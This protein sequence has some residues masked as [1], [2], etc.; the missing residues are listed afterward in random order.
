MEQEKNQWHPGFT[1]AMQME[2]K[3]NREDLVF[4][5]EHSLSKK[6]L[7]IDLLVIKNEKNVVLKNRIGKLFKRYNVLEYKSPD[8]EMGVDT[9]YKVVAYACLY[10]AESD[11]ENGY[12]AKDITITL[13]RHRKPVRLMQYLKQEGYELTEAYP[14][15]YYISGKT[16]FDVQ[17]IVSREVEEKEHVWLYSLQR[18]IS[19]EAYYRLL[20]SIDELEAKEKEEY[21]EAVLEVVS[22]ANMEN[23]EK[24]KEAEEMCATLEKIM[25][26]ELEQKKQEGIW[27]GRQEGMIIAYAELG[28]SVQNIAEKLSLSVE[29]VEKIVEENAH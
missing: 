5:E 22:R 24:W 11:V 1:A 7:Q 27:E 17:I 14:G 2:L 9:F 4:E 21:G 15:I 8:D 6:P 3:D 28:I 13:I 20:M 25:A 29:T 12:E 16:M 19:W 10:K 23:I 26:P 18:D